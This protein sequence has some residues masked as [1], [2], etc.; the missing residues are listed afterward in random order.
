MRGEKKDPTL[1]CLQET[2]FSIKDTHRLKG[3]G[4][5]EKFHVNENLEKAWVVIRISDQ[6]DF[7]TKTVVRDNEGHCIM[8]KGSI[9]PEDVRFVYIY[10]PNIGT[11]K[12]IEQKLT[13]L[14]GEIHSNTVVGDF[15]MPLSP[16]ARLYTQNQ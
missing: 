7:T 2:H 14:K 16:M 1:C 9:Q 3:K 6:A 11:P 12:Y 8:I 13:G 4:W 10:A 15:N 5:T